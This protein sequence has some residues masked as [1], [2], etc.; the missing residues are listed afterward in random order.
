MIKLDSEEVYSSHS[1]SH[2][3]SCSHFC[4]IYW[5]SFKYVYMF[6]ST[7]LCIHWIVGIWIK[8]DCTCMV[9]LRFWFWLDLIWYDA[10]MI[11]VSDF[12]K[13]WVDGCQKQ[14]P[15]IPWINCSL[16]LSLLL[17]LVLV[18]QSRVI[19]QWQSTS[20]H[21]EFD[22]LY[23]CKTD[24]YIVTSSSLSSSSLSSHSHFLV[25][26]DIEFDTIISFAFFLS[27][28][29]LLYYID[30]I[31][32]SSNKKLGTVSNAIRP[33][34]YNFDCN[35]EFDFDLAFIFVSFSNHYYYY[36]T[37]YHHRYRYRYR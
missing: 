37:C 31:A 13:V 17:Q 29:F 35:L 22:Y 7:L 15:P 8:D 25:L 5:K 24:P 18:P 1:H 12:A 34:N 3:R 19:D 6:M 21:W 30:K 4:Y 9:P 14:F 2:S 23:I 11:D 27:L 28:S 10:P 36:T 20:H 33:S 32:S 16:S 26:Y